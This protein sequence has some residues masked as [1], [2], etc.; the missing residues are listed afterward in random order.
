MQALVASAAS[1]RM[2]LLTLPSRAV[3]K[4]KSLARATIPETT[5][6]N[7]IEEVPTLTTRR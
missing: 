5:S 6:V 7:P 3:P 4:I 1:P 2:W